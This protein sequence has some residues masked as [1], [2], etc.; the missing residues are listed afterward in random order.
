[1][2][3]FRKYNEVAHESDSG[4]LEQ[5]LEQ[6]TRLAHRLSGVRRIAAVVSGKGGVGK[7]A[8]TANLAVALALHGARVGA[9]DADLNGPSL[10]RMLAVARSPLGEDEYGVRPATGVFGVRVMSMDLMLAESD[11]PLRWKGPEGDGSVWRGTAELG[12]LREFL[13]DVAWGQLDWLLI[14]LPP[15]T[16]RIERLLDLI[17]R[18]DLVLLVTTPSAIARLV[19]GRSARLL[20]EAGVPRVAIVANMTSYVD[21]TGAEHPLFSLD[22]VTELARDTAFPVWAKIPFEPAVAALTDAGSPIVSSQPETAAARALG[23][24]ARQMEDALMDAP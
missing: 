23:S 24:L 19:V 1:M 17:P 8:I 5:V 15:G 3:R 11:T 21:G 12:A 7:S 18:P 6:R 2:R 14:D 9:L 10:G 20:R 4:I 13:A 22:G 16:D